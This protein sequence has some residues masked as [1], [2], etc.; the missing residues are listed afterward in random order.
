MHPQI[1][2]FQVSHG[3]RWLEPLLAELNFELWIGDASG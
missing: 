3:M 2:T 1:V